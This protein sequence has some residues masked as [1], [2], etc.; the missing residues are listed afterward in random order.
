MNLRIVTLGCTLIFGLA[1]IAHAQ[2]RPDFR[3]KTIRRQQVEAPK[4]GGGGDLGGQP[5]QLWRQWYKIEVQFESEP[6]WADDVKLKY[7]VLVGKGK[8]QRLF[9]GEVTHVDVAKG[10]QHYSAMFM[11]PNTLKRYGGGQVEAVAIQ[12]WAK[13]ALVDQLSDPPTR[14]R[15]W[16]KLAPVPGYLLAP[17]ETPWAP[18]ASDRF[19]AI[20]TLRPSP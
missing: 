5:A 12:L 9:S 1:G 2:G 16:E 19:E 18:I 10:T 7:Y 3:I 17:N 20:K 14:E 8:E 13:G 11:H 6:D 15:W 4:Y